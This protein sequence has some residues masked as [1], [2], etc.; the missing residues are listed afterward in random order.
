MVGLGISEPQLFCIK[1]TSSLSSFV[2]SSNSSIWELCFLSINF[3]V[4][5][6]FPNGYIFIYGSYLFSCAKTKKNTSV[7]YQDEVMCFSSLLRW[8]F[9]RIFLGLIFS[10]ILCG[11]SERE[12][13]PKAWMVMLVITIHHHHHP[14]SIIHHHPSSSINTPCALSWYVFLDIKKKKTSTSDEPWLLWHSIA[15]VG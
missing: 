5:Q 6:Y 8:I 14:S 3:W 13:D 7:A 2:G 15:L 4:G 1:F 11:W 9:L 12:V 10:W